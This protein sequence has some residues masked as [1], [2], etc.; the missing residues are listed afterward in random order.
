MKILKIFDGFI[1]NSSSV[2]FL[3]ATREEL[4]KKII[5]ENLKKNPKTSSRALFFA[6]QL[7]ESINYDIK[8]E[9]KPYEYEFYE[10]TLGKGDFHYYP[11]IFAS[12]DHRVWSLF[13]LKIDD[14]DFKLCIGYFEK[15]VPWQKKY[16]QPFK[17]K[18]IELNSFGVRLYL[19]G[20]GINDLN[21]LHGLNELQN[22][23]YLD[24]HR[25][26]IKEIKGLDALTELR[27][28]NLDENKIERISGLTP[29]THLEELTID[30]NLIKK[31]EGLEGLTKLESLSLRENHIEELAD[32]IL[33]NLKKLYLTRNQITRIRTN[34]LDNL[35]YL[36]LSYNNISKLGRF[37]S[38]PNL[39]DLKL[40]GNSIKKIEDLDALENLEY[41]DLS[42]TR[43]SRIEGLENLK[44]LRWLN[45]SQTPIK[46]IEG[47]EN[48]TKLKYLNIIETEIP[49]DLIES[50]GGR[51]NIYKGVPNPQKYVEYCQKNAE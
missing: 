26:N 24:L 48:L 15:I 41:L 34:K 8:S 5:R 28:L 14:E 17:F 1:T 47:L 9:Q 40:E 32:L 46:R 43:I 2:N 50:L 36:N 51:G 44:N 33:P 16:R 21:D 31:I 4:T 12:D 42:E 10:I 19:S 11:G 38:F 18:N 29:L 6:N 49:D 23:M 20:R 25:N 37:D 3:L 27:M 30:R 39:V 45:L 35:T 7:W 22:I 13:G